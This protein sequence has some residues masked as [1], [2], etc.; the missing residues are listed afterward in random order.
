MLVLSRKESEVIVL[1]DEQNNREIRIKV[2]A[3]SGNRARIGIE[4][5]RQVKVMR[6]ELKEAS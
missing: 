4:A 1:T 3:I 5:D 6:S 2:V